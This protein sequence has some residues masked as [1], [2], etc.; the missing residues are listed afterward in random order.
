MTHK[1]VDAAQ[2]ERLTFFSDAV[3]AIA[4]TLLV[5][6]LKLPTLAT[7]DS[8]GLRHALLVM[9]PN[10]VGFIISFFVIGAY[11][12]AHRRTFRWVTRV[13]DKLVWR[14]LR[15]L[16]LIVFLPFPTVIISEYADVPAAGVF[17]LAVLGA[18]TLNQIVLMRYALLNPGIA[19]PEAPV[20]EIRG[21]FRRAWF[22]FAATVIAALLCATIP[23]LPVLA[24]MLL[25]S[26]AIWLATLGPVQR[27]AERRY[28]TRTS[29][30][31]ANKDVAPPPG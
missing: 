6:E 17:Y 9:S 2:V 1:S 5:I 26:F 10:F 25:P 28:R 12:A 16:L 27:I 7:R 19:S 3:F 11:W 8:E 24:Y 18:A 21:Y 22:L 31:Q 15:F 29:R 14:N 20:L 13:D 30:A 23:R 4:I